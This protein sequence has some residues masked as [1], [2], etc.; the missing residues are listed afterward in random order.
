MNDI[1]KLINILDKIKFYI[2]G[3]LA[4]L[5]ALGGFHIYKVSE[6]TT[7]VK[8]YL[9]E[10]KYA[11]AI[12]EYGKYK[13]KNLTK[14]MTIVKDF[15]SLYHIETLQS[16][17]DYINK[18]KQTFSDYLN[19]EIL[20]TLVSELNTIESDINKSLADIKSMTDMFNTSLNE[21]NLTNAGEILTSLKEK[22]PKEDF[23]S[24]SSRFSE[25]QKELESKAEEQAK[26]EEE[27]KEAEVTEVTE[28]PANSNEQSVNEV[29]QKTLSIADTYAAQNSGQLIT[30]VSSGGVTA[31]LCRWEK[32]SNG[33]WVQLDST[34]AYLG[35]GGM[36]YGPSVYNWDMCTP[37]GSYS[38][39]EAFGNNGN[40][41]TSLPYRVLDGSEH[42]ID[43]ENSEYYN[44]MQFGDPAG[45]WGSSEHL[46]SFGPAYNYSIV[47]DYNRWS[48]NP[49]GSSAIFLHCSTGKPT[50]GCLAVDEYK[51]V[52]I[53]N[54]I[55][56]SKNPRILLDFSYEEIY[57]NY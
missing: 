51:M 48:V 5:I 38:L 18:I 56:T 55:D 46:S 42:W 1:T 13:P 52:E 45:R 19:D 26:A 57:S 11:D 31:E 8:T 6:S 50:W 14:H 37:T 12:N 44:T 30:V 29:P 43:D 3:I 16:R 35:S 21:V 2:I 4:I 15:T 17:L 40:P 27:A 54:W 36:K 9:S 24:L 28:E 33:N 47:V 22:Y 10:G 23:D 39:T 41:G 32:D 25:K 53:L 20:S 34:Q 49:G 7:L